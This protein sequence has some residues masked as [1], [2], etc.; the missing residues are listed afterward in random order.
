MG[1]SSSKTSTKRNPLPKLGKVYHNPVWEALS[2][3]EGHAATLVFPKMKR[4]DSPYIDIGNASSFRV[5]Y[6]VV[7]EDK[8]V[9]DKKTDAVTTHMDITL[10]VANT[11]GYATVGGGKKVKLTKEY[12]A[13][14]Y[15][16]VK[17]SRGGPCDKGEVVHV[18][19]VEFPKGVKTLRVF[20]YFEVSGTWIRFKDKVYSIQRGKKAFVL[21][22]I[23]QVLKQYIEDYNTRKQFKDY[24]INRDAEMELTAQASNPDGDVEF[25]FNSPSSG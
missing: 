18:T 8:W 19:T 4:S 17:D 14:N 13:R 16:L 6:W 22:A 7:H 20:G 24:Q 3:D 15:F 12:S 23:N 10:G 11:V 2:N 5:S 9:R 25:D 1:T 21:T